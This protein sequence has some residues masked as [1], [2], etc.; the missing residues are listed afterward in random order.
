[1][2]QRQLVDA[3]CSSINTPVTFKGKH[4]K[5]MTLWSYYG[6]VWFSAALLSSSGAVGLKI[7]VSC[8]CPGCRICL[9]CANR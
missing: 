3:K 7:L 6:Q 4:L 9:D 1:M 2:C 5:V 8:N